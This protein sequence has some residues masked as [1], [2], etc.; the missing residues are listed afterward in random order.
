MHSSTEGPGSQ[1]DSVTHISRYVSFKML[2]VLHWKL[3]TYKSNQLCREPTW[4]DD[5]LSSLR[6]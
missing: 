2:L 3:Q 5:K 4:K 1:P 6:K